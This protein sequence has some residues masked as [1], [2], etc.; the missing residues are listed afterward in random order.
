[1]TTEIISFNAT[2]GIR[3]DGILSKCE[4]NTKKVVIQIHGMTSNCFKKRDRLIAKKLKEIQIDT[5][6]FNN[7]GSEIVRYIKSEK[8]ILLAGTAY[9]KVEDSYYDIVGAI[10]FA[11]NLGYESIYLQGHSLGCTKIVYT[12]NKLCEEN[13]TCLNSIKGVILLSLV[14]IPGAVGFGINKEYIQ[15]AEEKQKNGEL[16]DLMPFKSFIHPISVKNF[17]YYTKH[18]ENINFARYDEKDYKFEILNKIRCPLFMRWGNVNE[19]IKQDAKELSEFMNDKISNPKKD[20]SYIDGADHSYH[21]KNEELAL[22]IKNFLNK[23][24]N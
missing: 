13:N 17:L 15:F 21:G 7:R 5:I 22:Q 9:E 2:D 4:K 23:Q 12:Y 19:M 11:Q 14:D 16:M 6:S 24:E 18:N 20:I 3:L 10:K 8:S 1:M